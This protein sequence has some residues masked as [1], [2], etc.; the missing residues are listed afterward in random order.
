MAIW[1]KNRY[2]KKK[3]TDYGLQIKD[4]GFAMVQ[5]PGGVAV[6]FFSTECLQV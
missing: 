4:Y 5:G 1:E 3:I 2:T 6:Y